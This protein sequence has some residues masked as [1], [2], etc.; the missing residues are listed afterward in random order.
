MA[1]VVLYRFSRL[2]RLMRRNL[3]RS[4]STLVVLSLLISLV[5]WAGA[6]VAG[7]SAFAEAADYSTEVQAV[8]S[9]HSA[10][11]NAVPQQLDTV[12]LPIS[13]VANVGQQD[14]SV[15]F[16]AEVPGSTVFFAPSE[17]VMVSLL[18][19]PTVSPSTAPK[20][21]SV[22]EPEPQETNAKRSSAKLRGSVAR[23]RFINAN[24]NPN[25]VAG[26]VLPGKVN[27]FRGNDPS[28]WHPNVP[29]YASIKYEGLFPGIDLTYESTEHELKSTYHV[30]QGADPSLLRW[31]YEGTQ[32]LSVD[33]SGN[34]NVRVPVLRGVGDITS[35]D[36]I[37]LTEHA[38]AA[39]QEIKGT[40]VP[41]H[42]EYKVSGDGTVSFSLGSYDNT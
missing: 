26:Q 21:G 41:I 1:N 13:F 33:A 38:P 4:L 34:L 22:Q 12:D 35:T 3:Y 18:P 24:P 27:Y 36:S 30:A 20:D 15:R 25:I 29:T 32:T 19:R 7:R 31:T 2:V 11:G 6:P 17:V 42:V 9:A 8:Q 39:W 16:V 23:L 37:T 14:P 28:K 10:S 5:P 40:R